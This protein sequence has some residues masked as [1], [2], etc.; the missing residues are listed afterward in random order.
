MHILT[1]DPTPLVIMGD[2]NLS[3][4]NWSTLS[5]HTDFSNRFCDLAFES[6]LSQLVDQ[7]THI[8]G[9][10]LDL[11]LTNCHDQINSLTIHPH[12]YYSITSDHYLVSF[13][14]STDLTYKEDGPTT[15]VY[16][17]A[18]GDYVGLNN[19]LSTYDFSAFYS[20]TD[21]EQAWS[22]IKQCLT[23][24]IDLFIPKVRS[25][26][27]Q[28]PKW[29]SSDLKHQLNCLRTSRKKLRCHFTFPNSSN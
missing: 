22:I 9:N 20:T 16:N 3:D 1:A 2:F 28:Y 17:F 19:Y 10:I 26:P 6:N 5:D 12:N 27:S 15:Y 21:V 4:V 13:S 25:K 23:T 18:K 24:A 8:C 11:V 7:S 14:M 29:F